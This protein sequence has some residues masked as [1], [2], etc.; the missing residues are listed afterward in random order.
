[1]QIFIFY[2]DFKN[3]YKCKTN[4]YNKVSENKYLI[5]N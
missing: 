2:V 3:L 4:T 5:I 1:M